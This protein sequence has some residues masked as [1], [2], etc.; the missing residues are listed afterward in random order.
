M[1][2]TFNHRQGKSWAVTL[3]GKSFKEAGHGGPHVE[4]EEE[5][6][7]GKTFQLGERQI[8]GKAVMYL[9]KG[10]KNHSHPAHI[11]VFF[12]DP[13]EHSKY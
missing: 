2:V 5:G 10:V 13:S 12:G 1:S 9:V 8:L 4:T 3:Q 7:A 11:T 6:L